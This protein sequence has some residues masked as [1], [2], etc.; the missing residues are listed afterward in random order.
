MRV[1]GWQESLAQVFDDAHGKRFRWGA[2]DCC[3]F[4]ARCSRALTGVDRRAIFAAYRTRGEAQEILTTCGGMRGLL[5]RAFGEPVHPSRAT[6]GDIVLV[7][8]GKG[9]QPAVCMG[10]RAFAP[11]ARN[12]E[13]RDTLTATDAWIL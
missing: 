4:V 5:T 7:D 8:M 10:V 3:L 1:L 2:H 11:G 12:L 6:H 13:W 9:P